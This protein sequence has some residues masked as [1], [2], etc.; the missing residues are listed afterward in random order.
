VRRG[1]RKGMDESGNG[2][3]RREEGGAYHSDRVRF[4]LQGGTRR[5]TRTGAPQDAHPPLPGR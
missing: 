5:R 1:K 4:K 2:V 3:E